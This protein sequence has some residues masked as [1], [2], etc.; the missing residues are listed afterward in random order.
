MTDTDNTS[1]IQDRIEALEESVQYFSS[2]NKSEREIWVAESFINNLNI[3]YDNSEFLAPQQDPPDVTFRSAQF[4]IKEILDPGRRRHEEYKKKLEHARTISDPQELLR[5]FT[6]IDKTITEIYE[7]CLASTQKLTKYPPAVRSSTDLLYYVNLQDVMG[8]TETPFPGIDELQ[9]LGWR[10]VSFVQGHRS[11]VFTTC[12]HAP[13]FLLKA[14]H[15][16]HHRS[17]HE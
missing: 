15:L 2:H 6:P 3:S 8:L 10:S 16:I 17:H 7:L 4:E 11:C 1:L 14:A 12:E 5:Q 9:E 13:E